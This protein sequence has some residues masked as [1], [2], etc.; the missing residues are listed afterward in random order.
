M[1]K[2]FHE[3]AKMKAHPEKK[4]FWWCFWIGMIGWTMVI[5][6]PDRGNTTHQES[7]D[8]EELTEL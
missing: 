2:Q 8:T 3:I 6:L 4:F 1:A 5:A 7:A